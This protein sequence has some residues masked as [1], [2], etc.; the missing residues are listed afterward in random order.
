MLSRAPARDR[1]FIKKDRQ[2][3]LA[4]LA[5]QETIET[6]IGD[7]SPISLSAI[8]DILDLIG[9]DLTPDAIEEA[10]VETMGD[11]PEGFDHRLFEDLSSTLMESCAGKPL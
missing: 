4:A 6:H 9:Q 5:V 8:K 10:V 2:M 3:N 7:L 11:L 1:L